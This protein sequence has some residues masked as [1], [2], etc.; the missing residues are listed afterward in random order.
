MTLGDYLKE[1]HITR[2]KFAEMVGVSRQ[3]VQTWLSG[4]KPGLNLAFV[5]DKKTGGMVPA[6]SW[7]RR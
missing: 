5:I 7:V 3:T 1:R 6:D 4:G 2:E